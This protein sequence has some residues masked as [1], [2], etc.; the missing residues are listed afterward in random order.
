VRVHPPRAGVRHAHSAVRRVRG[1][2]PIPVHGRAVQVEPIKPALKAP[3]SERLKLNCDDVLSNFAFKFN[4]RRYNTEAHR[5]TSSA[6][7]LDRTLEHFVDS[8]NN[9]SLP[10]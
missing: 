9:A 1:A 5:N 6:A 10:I 8:F 3:G 2:L 4:L 7:D